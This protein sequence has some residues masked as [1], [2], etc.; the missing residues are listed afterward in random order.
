MPKTKSTDRRPVTAATALKKEEYKALKE[1]MAD[2]FGITISGMLRRIVV[3]RL[4]D[5]GYL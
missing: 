4:R 3:E 1:M 2:N 5:E